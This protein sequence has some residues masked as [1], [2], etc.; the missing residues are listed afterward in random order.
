[1]I[2]HSRLVF[3]LHKEKSVENFFNVQVHCY[4]PSKNPTD[5]DIFVFYRDE[6]TSGDLFERSDRE[7]NVVAWLLLSQVLRDPTNFIQD[8]ILTI[9]LQIKLFGYGYEDEDIESKYKET[10]CSN[11]KELYYSGDFSDFTIICA[12]GVR[13]PVH[14]CIMFAY[15]PVFKAMLQTNMIESKNNVMEVN[16]IDGHDMNGILHFMY[17][18]EIENISENL[19][20]LMYGAE[21]YQLLE[22]KERCINY[23][24]TFISRDNAIQ[25]YK[26]CCL[27]DIKRMVQLCI[28]YIYTFYK[29]LK[30]TDEW[31]DLNIFELNYIEEALKDY[32]VRFNVVKSQL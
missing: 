18:Q 10:I 5:D 17:T 23:M 4:I 15:S 2:N 14:R 27:Y 30:A 13:F 20:G 32:D 3:Y 1:M 26:I 22:L 16:D 24:D 6:S 7:K 29:E 19:Q 31:K 21:K 9:C 12:D 25:F 8:N 28:K 11:F